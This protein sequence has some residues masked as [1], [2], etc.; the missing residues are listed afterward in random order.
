LTLGAGAPL[1]PAALKSGL[2][3]MGLSAVWFAHRCD[4]TKRTVFRW[5]DGVSPI[6]ERAV[7]AFS[8]VWNFTQ[9]AALAVF[10]EVDN[11]QPVLITYRTDVEYWK[12]IESDEYPASWH[13]ALIVRVADHL[14]GI[15]V[16]IEYKT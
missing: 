9:Q 14:N 1:T 2:D 8:E 3:Y 6:P 15:P 13:R 12:V 5:F 7:E 11:D 10:E 16:Q 4:V